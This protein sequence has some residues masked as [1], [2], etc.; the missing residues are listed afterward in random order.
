[1]ELAVQSTHAPE[2]PHELLALPTTHI[3]PLQQPPMHGWLAP[4]M[5]THF[6]DAASHAVPLGQSAAEVHPHAPARQ[7]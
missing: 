6:F 3:V 1:M 7:V 5:V 4:H 2:A